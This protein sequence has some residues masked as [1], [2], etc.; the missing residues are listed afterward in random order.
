[1]AL[2]DAITQA[3]EIRFLPILLTSATAIGGLL[4]LALQGSGLY[5][6]LAIV[7]I[8]G[9]ISSTLLGRLVTPVMYK[10]L[11]PS[12]VAQPAAKIDASLLPVRSG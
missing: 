9:L 10:L 8:G 1:V 3:G 4:P 11:P 12:I 6:P 7:I 2:D 5:S